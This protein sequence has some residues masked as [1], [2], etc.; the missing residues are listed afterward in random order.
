MRPFFPLVSIRPTSRRVLA[1]FSAC[2]LACSSPAATTPTDND[3]SAVDA[4]DTTIADTA[5]PV[6][7]LILRPLHVSADRRVVDDLDREVLLRGVNITSLGEYWQ[8]DATLKPTEELTAD[9]WD[10][11]AAQGFNVVRLVVHWSQ[12]EPTR[13]TLNQAYLAR[14]DDYVTAAATHGMYTVIDMH[15]DAYS[16]FIFTSLASE[17]TGSTSPAKGWDGAPKWAVMT[18]GLSTCITGDRNS[19]PAVTAA[20]NHFYDNT[21]GIQDRFVATWAGLAAHFAGRPEVAGYDLLNEPEVSRPAAQLGP[22]YNQ[23]IKNTVL[24]I[25]AA[26]K[27]AEFAHLQII[28]PA[29]AAGHPEFGLAVPD[30]A[31]VGLDLHN[32]VAG[33]HN[34]AEAIEIG[35]GL[36]IEDMSALYLGAADGMGVPMWVGEHGFWS[37]DAETVAKLTR[38]AA[39]EDARLLG[40]AW[41]QW[42]QPCGDPHSVPWGG[43]AKDG[44][45][46]QQIHL[47][48]VACPSQKDLG[49]TEPLLRVVRRAT[50]RFAPGRIQK[51]TSDPVTGKFSLTATQATPG[52]TLVVWL[53]Q[54]PGSFDVS[55]TNLSELALREV[56]GGRYLVAQVAAGQTG[57]GVEVV[58][59]E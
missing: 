2:A 37:A 32:L 49:P 20:W 46:N 7:P 18:D 8:G 16:A 11:M 3:T 54:M 9:D 24:A 57:Y 17:C 29:F 28:E 56:P 14:I 31:G 1:L 48:G 55:A 34:Y 38:Y 47:H 12:L 39:D 58:P 23:L 30:P 43:Y 22:L 6:D 25:R 40:G 53:P 59:G 4:T 41:W 15:Q 27:S 36:S 10:E 45:T 51:L 33:P 5:T 35:L 44:Q 42:R 19:S 52:A 13:G 26:E 50:P 21:D